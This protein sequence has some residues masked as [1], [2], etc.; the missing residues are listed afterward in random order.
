MDYDELGEGG[1]ENICGFL[2]VEVKD[3][4]RERVAA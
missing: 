1:Q 3:G 2:G 4:E